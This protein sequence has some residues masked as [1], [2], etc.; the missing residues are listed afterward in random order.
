[1]API[2]NIIE[3]FPGLQGAMQNIINN[4]IGKNTMRAYESAIRRYRN[5]CEEHGYEVEQ[6]TEDVLVHYIAW[7]HEQNATLAIISQVKPAIQLLLEIQTGK[8]EVFTPRVMRMLVGAKR[9]AAENRQPVK[10]APEVTLRL[11]QTM[12]EKYVLQYQDNIYKAPI[13]RLRTVTQLVVEYYTFCRL[14]DYSKLQ[15]QHVEL[16]GNDMKIL[17]PTSKNDQYHNGQRTVITANGSATCPVRVLRLYYQRL[18]F[19]FGAAGGDTRYLHCRIRKFGGQWFADSHAASMGKAREELK[20]LLQELGRGPE[21]VTDKSFKML[22][23][24]KTLNAGVPVDDVARHGRWRTAD[25]PLRYQHNSFETKKKI[26]GKIPG[27][28]ATDGE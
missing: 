19:R 2:N 12:V 23:V 27:Q 16:R 15:A 5:F 1:V 24:T 25:M 6:T 14:A 28:E 18:G 7:L 13:Y 4:T 17:F 26:A 11:L 3:K 22:G 21:R 20:D 8:A 9:K 10:K